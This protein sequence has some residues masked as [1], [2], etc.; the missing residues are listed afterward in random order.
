MERKYILLIADSN[1]HVRRFLARELGGPA[2]EILEAANH[3]QLFS[4]IYGKQTPDL[5]IIDLDIPYINCLDVLK[6]IQDITPPI[7]V[8]IYTYLA[9]YTL[10]QE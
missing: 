10:A 9:E 8:I 1:P 6:Q 4:K 3:L 7:P 5:I 2:Y